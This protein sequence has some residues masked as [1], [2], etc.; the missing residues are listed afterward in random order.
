MHVSAPRNLGD[1]GGGIKALAW[2]MSPFV[3][4]HGWNAR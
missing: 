2:E 4:R 1:P 3:R